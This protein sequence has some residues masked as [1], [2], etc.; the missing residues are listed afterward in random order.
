M[1]ETIIQQITAVI[2]GSEV[3]LE[4]S[5][6]NLT[7]VVVSER[8]AGMTTVARQQLVYQALQSLIS[9]GALHAIS[10]QTHTPA[11]RSAEHG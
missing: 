5:G 11:E 3:S 4:G 7:A 2:P 9:S 10:L 6:C 1:Q 8:F